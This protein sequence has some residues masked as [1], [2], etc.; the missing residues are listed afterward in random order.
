M[1]L[2]AFGLHGFDVSHYQPAAPDFTAGGRRFGICKATEGVGV[3]DAHLGAN[4]AKAKEQG[5][6]AFGLY[7]FARP[8][9]HAAVAEADHF[10]A[11]AGARRPGEFAILDYEVD[12]WSQAWA[13]A[14]LNRVKAAGWPIV[15]YSYR[16]MLSAHTHD[17]IQAT[18]AALWVASYSSKEP[19]VS[20][21]VWTF[22][23]HTDGQGS[24][25]G[26]DG[27]WDCSVFHSNDLNDLAAFA[28]GSPTP[29]PGGFLMA[30]SDAQQQE[31]YD[32]VVATRAEVG[33]LQAI[34]TFHQDIQRAIK[35]TV[36]AIKADVEN[37]AT[38]GGPGQLDSATLDQIAARVADVA[39]A[40][41]KA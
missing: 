2:S 13:V 34:D 14:W 8:A 21:W 3:L 39:A 37:P 19:A 26:N 11:A 28:G 1:P 18:G 22:W 10:L 36:E 7:H 16:A 24:V 6:L 38:H 20:G 31:I 27:P 4:R 32:K 41:L 35:A 5:L 25:A 23:Q 33:N 9:S 29:P 17:A 30:L 12:P 15:F 40:R